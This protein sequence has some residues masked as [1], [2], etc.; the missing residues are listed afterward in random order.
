[1]VAITEQRRLFCELSLNEVLDMKDNSTRYHFINVV[2]VTKDFL[3]EHCSPLTESDCM[4]LC[5]NPSMVDSINEALKSAGIEGLRVQL[6][7]SSDQG[8]SWTQYPKSR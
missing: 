5:K 6:N 7:W 4:A 1:M 8:G 2:K 3:G